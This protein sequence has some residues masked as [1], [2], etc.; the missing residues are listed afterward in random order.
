[1]DTAFEVNYFS[2][3]SHLHHLECRV[4][5]FWH[6]LLSFVNTS[7]VPN[8]SAGDTFAVNDFSLSVELCVSPEKADFAGTGRTG[9]RVQKENLGIKYLSC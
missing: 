5:L 9:G 3:V 4:A 2:R 1:L 7:F 6:V 8:F